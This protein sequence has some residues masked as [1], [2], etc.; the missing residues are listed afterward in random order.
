M[1]FTE[2]IDAVKTGEKVTRRAWREAGKAKVL[3]YIVG[4]KIPY[5]QITWISIEPFVAQSEAGRIYAYQPE[6]ADKAA[7]D[8]EIVTDW[9]FAS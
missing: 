5:R 1:D 2:A 3:T 9:P 8:F 6:K 4:A 7:T